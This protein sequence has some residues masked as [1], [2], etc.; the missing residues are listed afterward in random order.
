VPAYAHQWNRKSSDLILVATTGDSM[1]ECN[2]CHRPLHDCDVCEGQTR[3]SFLGDRLACSNCNSTGLIC[4]I[5]GGH[6][7]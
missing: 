6:W 2:K 5:H 7:K 3:K 1:K 4:S